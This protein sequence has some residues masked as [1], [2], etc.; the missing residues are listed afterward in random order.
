[1]PIEDFS[2]YSVISEIL[3]KNPQNFKFVHFHTFFEFFVT[4]HQNQSFSGK[5]EISEAL[6]KK[7]IQ[8]NHFL[9]INKLK[10]NALACTAF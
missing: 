5:T 9:K 10:C 2:R 3:E 7:K 8:E 4:K 6:L 1:M